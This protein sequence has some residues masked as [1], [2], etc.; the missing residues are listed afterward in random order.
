MPNPFPLVPGHEEDAVRRRPYRDD[1]IFSRIGS[2]AVE[3]LYVLHGAK[4][5]DSGAIPDD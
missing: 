4:H 1:L 5:Y 2:N 3:I